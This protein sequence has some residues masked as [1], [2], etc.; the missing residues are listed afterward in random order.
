MNS[1]ETEFGLYANRHDDD[2]ADED[3]GSAVAAAAAAAV[4]ATNNAIGT[5]TF[6]PYPI[7]ASGPDEAT[8]RLRHRHQAVSSGQEYFPLQHQQLPP[9]PPP[10]SRPKVRSFLQRIP[11]TPMP[12]F[13]EPRP[14]PWQRARTKCVLAM[15]EYVVQPYKRLKRAF[16]EWLA[17]ENNVPGRVSAAIKRNQKY[18]AGMM[19]G[20]CATFVTVVAVLFLT[21]ASSP[22]TNAELRAT[23]P[24]AIP[25]A[26]IPG[27]G[28]FSIVSTEFSCHELQAGSVQLT[29]V[30][31][32]SAAALF[33][34]PASGNEAH[35]C[36]CAPMVGAFRR[37]LA[38]VMKNTTTV[39]H[40][41]N[42][43]VL[44]EPPPG[45]PKRPQQFVRSEERLDMMFPEAGRKFVTNARV[46]SLWL[47]YIVPG[48]DGC[49]TGA[50]FLTEKEAI[51]AQMCLDLFDGISVY[52]RALKTQ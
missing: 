43:K 3:G 20:C 22:L 11:P 13:T 45:R 21:G 35:A 9:P 47:S 8:L 6:D 34:T 14:W 52:Q 32:A 33:P 12:T 46:D 16:P 30:H 10:Q 49:N 24:G 23:A 42:V 40:M 36:V 4:F 27:T 18:V 19:T 28:N 41:Y 17:D 39:K 5:A 25:W 29:R 44:A 50:I 1:A 26:I 2:D 38:I 15:Q 31:G 7:T 37:H 48:P 51:C